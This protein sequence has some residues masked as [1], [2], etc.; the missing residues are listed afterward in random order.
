MKKKQQ[1]LFK[2]DF[3]FCYDFNV[4]KR[5]IETKVN[6]RALCIFRKQQAFLA[7]A[8][9]SF[10]YFKQKKKGEK[11]FL[12]ILRGFYVLDAQFPASMEQQEQTKKTNYFW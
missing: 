9:F 10:S 5:E 3:Y 11:K 12:S 7:W 2:K 8:C 4:F 1:Q 6:T